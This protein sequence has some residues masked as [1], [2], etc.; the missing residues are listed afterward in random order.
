MYKSA[1]INRNTSIVNY[2]CFS[3]ALQPFIQFVSVLTQ[4]G[5]AQNNYSF[6]MA[7]K[8]TPS[9]LSVRLKLFG[10]LQIY[11]SIYNFF[12][13]QCRR[14]TVQK[15]LGFPSVYQQHWLPRN[16]FS[17]KWLT[18]IW[19]PF[20]WCYLTSI[21]WLTAV[22]KPNILQISCYL[23]LKITLLVMNYSSYKPPKVKQTK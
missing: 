9:Q 7:L 10:R 14:K 11:P 23:C 21:S 12:Q 17:V 5:K 20:N 13:L 19:K 15:T 3:T 2:V 8:L 6:I 22:S 4:M 1:T 16:S 18:L